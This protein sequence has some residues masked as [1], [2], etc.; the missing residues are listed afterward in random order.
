MNNQD[1][2]NEL[3]KKYPDFIYEK[4]EILFDSERSK[5]A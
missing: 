4:Y 5:Q 1:K 2:F 3:R